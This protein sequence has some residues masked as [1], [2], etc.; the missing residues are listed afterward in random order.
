MLGFI[1]RL[2]EVNVSKFEL[3]I[4]YW[5]VWVL[6]LVVGIVLEYVFNR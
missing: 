3:F 2:W 6:I 4:D 5:Y 1:N